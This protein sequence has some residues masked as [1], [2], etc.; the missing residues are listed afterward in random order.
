MSALGQILR[1]ALRNPGATA[2]VDDQRTYSYIALAGGAFFL[3]NKIERTTANR[4]VGILLP[5]SGAFALALMGT[6]LAKRVAVPLNYLLSH[7]E[8]AYV[9]NDSEIDTIVTVDRILD[10]LKLHDAIP[11]SVKLLK[12]DDCDFDGMPPLRWP[13]RLGSGELA[14]ILYTSGTSGRPKGVM[15]SHGNLESNVEGAIEHARITRADTFVGV[16]PQFHCFGLTGL[17]LLPLMVGAKVVYTSRFLPKRIV[18]LIRKHR[19]EIFM[20]VPSMYGALLSVKSATAADF[21]SI[22]F[23]ISG[24]EPLPQA[25]FDA[26]EQRFNLRLLEGYGLTETAP[27]TNWATPWDFKAHSVGRAL[28]GVQIIVVDENDRILGPDCDGEILMNGP[29][30]MSGYFKLPE[31]TTNA[32]VEIDLPDRGPVRFF[33]SGDIGHTD[34]EGFLFITGRKK[35]MLIIGGENVFP[36]EIEEVLNRHLSVKDSAV[37]GKSDGLRGEVPIAF[38]ELVEAEDFDEQSVRNWCRESLAQFKVPREVRVMDFLPRNPTGK[39]LRR[40]LKVE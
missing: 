23:P 30:I 28:S 25:T 40:A 14:V 9:I 19:P 18:S 17:T 10:F 3:A 38:V 11:P 31:Q 39:I 2:A 29:N 37:I 27:I 33:R 6:W 4:H 5:T 32:F 7:D 26:Y 36:R 13:P 35:E 12:L 34:D 16:L 24:G 20:A 21:S 1:N 8:L 15:L 22:R